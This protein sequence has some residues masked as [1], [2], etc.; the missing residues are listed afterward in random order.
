MT[1]C[2]L[3]STDGRV[4]CVGTYEECR[5]ISEAMKHGLTGLKK[6]AYCAGLNFTIETAQGDY[7]DPSA[8][9]AY[10]LRYTPTSP[11]LAYRILHGLSK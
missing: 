11:D 3:I 2:R 7:P 1:Y 6:P 4:F 9:G 10:D 5:K 8:R